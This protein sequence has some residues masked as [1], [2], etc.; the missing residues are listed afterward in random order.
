MK[1]DDVEKKIFV[2]NGLDALVLL[3]Q[4]KLEDGD[5]KVNESIQDSPCSVL[6]ESVCKE[7]HDH[8]VKLIH[9]WNAESL[10]NLTGDSMSNGE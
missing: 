5:G 6:A 3:A 4:G 8:F 1:E 7:A 9:K 2:E 10:S